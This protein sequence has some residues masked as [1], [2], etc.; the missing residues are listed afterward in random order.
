MGR[1]LNLPAPCGGRIYSS[2]FSV[3]ETQPL[4]C[5]PCRLWILPSKP[6]F[7]SAHRFVWRKRT[8]VEN[9]QLTKPAAL[10]PQPCLFCLPVPTNS[11]PQAAHW[12]SQP[13]NLLFLHSQPQSVRGKEQDTRW[14]PTICSPNWSPQQSRDLSWEWRKQLLTWAWTGREGGTS[15]SPIPIRAA[16]VRN[17]EHKGPGLC[18]RRWCQEMLCAI[19]RGPWPP[20]M[21][22]FQDTI[23]DNSGCS[24]SSCLSTATWCKA[25]H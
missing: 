21:Y 12:P 15:P 18:Q 25:F 8:M 14:F 20:R 10:S 4:V 19:T 7:K 24:I 23:K 3:R 5:D 2:S 11:P 1:K 9:V 22:A 13:T 17:H 6:D 16:S